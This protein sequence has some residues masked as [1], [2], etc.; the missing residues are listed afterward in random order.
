MHRYDNAKSYWKLLKKSCSSNSVK[1]LSSQ[2]FVD[3]FKAINNPDSIYF[4]P[5]DDILYFNQCYLNGELGVM[6]EELNVQISMQEIL[7][8]TFC[9]VS[10]PTRRTLF[11]WCYQHVNRHSQ[12]T[13]DSNMSC[14]VIHFYFKPLTISISLLLFI[15][16]ILFYFFHFLLVCMP[17]VI[18]SKHSFYKISFD[19]PHNNDDLL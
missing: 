9:L 6:F 10:R 3:Y 2:S 16:C 17:C 15:T 1:T 11:A 18:I 13:F 14:H 12:D 7:V 5:D 4:Q 8:T 19:L